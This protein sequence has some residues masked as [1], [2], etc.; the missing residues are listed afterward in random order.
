M[1]FENDAVRGE[2]AKA[3]IDHRKKIDRLREENE[4]S[5]VEVLQATFGMLEGGPLLFKRDR[6]LVR[7]DIAKE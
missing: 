1:T 2:L 6:R 5:G 4:N 3:L 7:E